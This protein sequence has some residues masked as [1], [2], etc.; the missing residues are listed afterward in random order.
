[1]FTINFVISIINLCFYLKQINIYIFYRLE[2]FLN[3]PE[4]KRINVLYFLKLLN[5][6]GFFIIFVL[7]Y[8]TQGVVYYCVTFAV[9]KWIC[10]RSASHHGEMDPSFKNI[11][12]HSSDPRMYCRVLSDN[13]S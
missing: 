12:I 13:I 4:T 1:M 9:H 5:N 11:E 8:S 3:D 2:L 6:D 7:V 10:L